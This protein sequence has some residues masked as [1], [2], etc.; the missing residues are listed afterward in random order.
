MRGQKYII[1]KMLYTHVLRRLGFEMHFTI[2]YH[3]L[4]HT[5]SRH[6]RRVPGTRCGVCEKWHYHWLVP[7]GPWATFVHNCRY[8][9]CVTETLLLLS[10]TLVSG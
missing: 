1:F 6:R 3:I 8:I 10:N 9:P 7:V 4:M 2:S 5:H